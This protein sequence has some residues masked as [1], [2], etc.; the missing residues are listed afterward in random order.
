MYFVIRPELEATRM[1]YYII[2]GSDCDKIGTHMSFFCLAMLTFHLFVLL[3]V[4][5]KSIL[6]FGKSFELSR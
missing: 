1:R 6:Q 3:L 2:I 4:D 5:S